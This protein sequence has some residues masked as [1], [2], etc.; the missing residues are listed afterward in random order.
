MGSAGADQR[1]QQLYTQ[2]ID[3]EPEEGDSPFNPADDVQVQEN[4]QAS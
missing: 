4:Q 3:G 1:E 2:L